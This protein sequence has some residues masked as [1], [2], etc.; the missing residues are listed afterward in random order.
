M[1]DLFQ[2][3]ADVEEGAEKLYDINVEVLG[4]SRELSVRQLYDPETFDVMGD[5]NQDEIEAVQE[6]V[7]ED[8]LD[9]YSELHEKDNLTEDEEDELVELTEEI[10]DED[11]NLFDTLSKSTFN[12][13]QKAAVHGVTPDEEDYQFAMANRTDEIENKYGDLSRDA[14]EQY[15]NDHIIPDMIKRSTDMSSFAIGIKVLGQTLGN[16]G[17]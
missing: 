15:I 7:P 14:A 4:E 1:S 9:R 16:T 3:R 17:N 10:E 2:T 8:K 5:I 13:I 6:G 11:I 12:G